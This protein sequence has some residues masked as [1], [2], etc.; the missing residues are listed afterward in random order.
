M[1]TKTWQCFAQV[2]EQRREGP[3]PIH[4]FTSQV[5][6]PTLNAALAAD[7][8]FTRGRKAAQPMCLRFPSAEL[9]VGQVSCHSGARF[10]STQQPFH[11]VHGAQSMPG[12]VGWAHHGRAAL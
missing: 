12:R 5:A 2:S 1:P 3:H 8:R 7:Q 11:P 6:V 4:T 9:P 10:K